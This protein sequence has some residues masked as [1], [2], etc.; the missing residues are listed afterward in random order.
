MT[1]R[2]SDP[3]ARF[4]LRLRLARAALLWEQIWPACWP[5]LAV[6]G[7]FFALALFDLLPHLPGL[8][9]AAILLGFG[10][11]FV[12]ALA[13]ANRGLIVPDQAAARRR[14]ELES[15]VEHRPLQAL[16]DDPAAPL[17]TQST[18]LW[19]AHRRRMEAATGR[20][21]V[22]FPAAGF[23][24]RDLWGLRVIL[25]ILLLLGTIDAGID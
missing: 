11:A 14:I 13:V 19:Q 25:V 22:G 15:G 16:A 6:L 4:W 8:L 23:A 9:H 12:V 1:D 17:D 20:L 7:V 18:Q 24:G 21:R 5:A 3:E 10:A 2:S